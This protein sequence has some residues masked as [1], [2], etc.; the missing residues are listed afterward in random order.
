M[1]IAGPSKYA[2]EKHPASFPPKGIAHHVQK[3]DIKAQTFEL[4]RFFSSTRG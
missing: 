2:G 1:F 4:L 3:E